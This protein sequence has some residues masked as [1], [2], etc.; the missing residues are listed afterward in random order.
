MSSV[1][2]EDKSVHNAENV[3]K[4]HLLSLPA[5]LREM[6]WSFVLVEPEP[7]ISYVNRRTIVNEDKHDPR[8]LET[9]RVMKPIPSLPP[10]AYIA[11]QLHA[12]IVAA[13]FGSN[14]FVFHL[15]KYNP[16][17]VDSWLTAVK[18]HISELLTDLDSAFVDGHITIRLDLQIPISAF[19]G[20]LAT[21][22]YS[23]NVKKDSYD[24][25]FSGALTQE[26]VCR[27][28]DQIEHRYPDGTGEWESLGPMSA[29]TKLLECWARLYWLPRDTT[30]R[31]KHC[32]H[33]C[34]PRYAGD[35]AVDQEFDRLLDECF[36]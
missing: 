17:E 28:Y 36:G 18:Y 6:I 26:C 25:K 8:R 20:R 16:R 1:V 33:C 19:L 10:L 11:K 35:G 12:E 3:P 13:F 23:F 7:I 30:T 4:C 31:P 15:N 2:A 5:E 32:L 22:E 21:I 34:R 14:T 9:L 27:L 29:V 24:I